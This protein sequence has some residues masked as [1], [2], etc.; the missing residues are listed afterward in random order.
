M[1]TTNHPLVTL[2][3]LANHKPPTTSPYEP[4]TL[5][6]NVESQPYTFLNPL[7]YAQFRHFSLPTLLVPI[8]GHDHTP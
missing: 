1:Q 2:L 3:I 5:R 6:V 4:S 8:V 7:N